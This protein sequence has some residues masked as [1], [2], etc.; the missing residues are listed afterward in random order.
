MAHIVLL[1]VKKGSAFAVCAIEE[2]GRCATLDFL[3]QMKNNDA[4]EHAK[5]LALLT[6]SADH[7]PPRNEEKSRPV[8]DGVFE[9]KT[10]RARVCYFYDAGK[11]IICTHGFGK[12]S[13]KVQDAEIA[14]AKETMV[15]YF[16]AKAQK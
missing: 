5:L 9:F 11:L 8:G 15:R 7:G 12:P 4:G 13:P 1:P 2:N 3:N 6:R 14:A 10:K 16:E